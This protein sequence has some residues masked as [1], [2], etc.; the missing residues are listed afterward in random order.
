VEGKIQMKTQTILQK[1]P[2]TARA[3]IRYTP[4]Q[5][6]LFT[7]IYYFTFSGKEGKQQEEDV[8]KN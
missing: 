6:H 7:N 8:I 1:F 2:T 5:H 4:V 3:Q